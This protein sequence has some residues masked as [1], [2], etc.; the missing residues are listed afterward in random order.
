[1][2]GVRSFFRAINLE[3]DVD[4]PDR[5]AHY[6]PTSRSLPVVDAVLG[7]DPTLVIAA[8]GS[9]KSLAAGIGA[10]AVVND[11]RSHQVVKAI[12]PKVARVDSDVH[13]RLR[14][15]TTERRGKA[16]ILSGHV[17]DLA[18]EIGVKLGAPEKLTTLERVLNWASA[19][20]QGNTHLAIVWDEFGRHL[21]SLVADGRSRE[22][23]L[24][25]RLAEWAARV[26]EP[27][28]SLTLL[29]HQNLLA[30][31]NG[32]NTTSR[33]E[34]R[35]IEGRFRTFRF[36]E[37]SRE[38]YRLLVERVR[39]RRSREVP[40]FAS[41]LKA[42]VVQRAIEAGWFDGA[43]DLNEV[44]NIVGG[45]WP[46]SAG[47]LQAL[48]RLAAR[49]GQNERSLF[50][51]LE[52]AD[53]SHPVRGTLSRV[54]GCFALRR[55]RWRHP[56]ALDRNRERARQSGE[57]KRARG[58]C[59]CMPAATWNRWRKAKALPVRARG[60]RRFPS[61]IASGCVCG[62]RSADRTK[63]A[64]AS[65]DRRRRVRVAWCRHRHR[66]PTCG[67]ASEAGRLL[68]CRRIPFGASPTPDCARH[69]AQR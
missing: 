4:V 39:E 21:E 2:N 10:L 35:K 33:N 62:C 31:A 25:Q 15:F 65:S 11:S 50:G 26:E 18:Q 53:L 36:V 38:L 13:Q 42:A 22:L 63:V 12:L 28:V 60:R 32:L 17:P 40:E 29:S 37:D 56:Q 49:V 52:D 67:G 51:F 45:A 55:R 8:Y 57:R 68:R 58:S 43:T 6:Q 34:W 3:F 19:N 44:A 20:L 61:H 14:R 24:V 54:L 27:T 7:R 46:V 30:Y 5:L 48:P 59:C 23:D 66:D 47:A 41:K 16:V 69:A 1:M 64:S 9:G